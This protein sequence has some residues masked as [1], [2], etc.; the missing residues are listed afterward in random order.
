HKIEGYGTDEVNC[1]RTQIFPIH[2]W[3]LK[4]NQAEEP[5]F[6]AHML[7]ICNAVEPVEF[8]APK[9]LAYIKKRVPQGKHPRAKSR[10]IKK[11]TSSK[12]HS[13]SKIE[14]IK[15]KPSASTPVVVELHK[16]D[17]QASSGLA[18]L[19]VTASTI[20]HSKSASEHD[21]SIASTAKADP[22]KYDPNDSVTKQQGI[23]KRTKKCSFDHIIA[24]TNPHVLID[25]SK[26]VSEGLETVHTKEG[27]G[28]GA[29]YVEKE[30]TFAED[31]FNTSPDLSSSDDAKKKIK[32]EDLS[33]LIPNVEVDF[34]DLD[35][36]EDDEPI[37]VLDE[38][39]E[40]VHAEKVHAKQHKEIEYVSASQPPSPKTVQIQE[41]S[42]QLKELPSKVND[43]FGELKDLKKYVHQLEIELTGDLKENPTKMEKF[44]STVSRLTTQA[45]INTLD[46][47]PT[48]DQSVPSA[49]QAGTQPAEGE[50]NTRQATITQL[51]KQRAAKDAKKSNLNSQ[52][53]PTTSPITITLIKN[54]GKEATSLKETEEEESKTDSELVVRL[55]GSMVESYK[56]K[57]LKKFDFVTKEGNHVYL[58]EE[59]IKEQKRF[60]ESVKANMAKKEEEVRKEELVDL[61][62]IDV[63]LITLKVYRED[64][65]NKVIPNFKANVLHLAE[66]REV[67]QKG[68]IVGSVP[69]PFSL[70]VDLNIKSPK[71]NLAEDKFSFV[72]LKTIQLQFFSLVGNSK[73]NDVDL[74]LEAETKCFSS[75]R[76]TRREK[77]AL[78]Q[79]E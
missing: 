1:N 34:I 41:L 47:L 24:G 40:E 21:A 67:Y 9:S 2:N 69:E 46:A 78:Y 73:L 57:R 23:V 79:K 62:G 14:A 76:F 37:I 18:S 72:A 50:K 32:L 77:I 74:L 31:E 12:H 44:Y 3:T 38:D 63:G 36:P 58:I 59:Q 22:R 61:L 33:K 53:I 68:D 55:T 64:G 52:P 60:K 70:L 17:L 10:H 39:E 27:T 6:T 65:S 19:E 20:I 49:G 26:S 4:K 28:K 75:R 66:W 45:K 15:S 30:I 51:F 42:T 25:K 8:Q 43:I 35:S 54:K 16:G 56:K 11:P 29:S 13:L 48:S 71:Y 5:P 7:A